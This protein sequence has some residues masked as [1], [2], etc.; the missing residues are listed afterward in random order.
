MAQAAQSTAGHQTA[1][2]WATT[3]ASAM[4]ASSACRTTRMRTP[5][6]QSVQWLRNVVRLDILHSVL[7]LANVYECF[8]W[9]SQTKTVDLKAKFLFLVTF[10]NLSLIIIIIIII[11]YIIII[12]IEY[13]STGAIEEEKERNDKK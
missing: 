10:L 5:T 11:I 9:H 4:A 2:S 13:T 1:M 12:I 3:A 6:A 7:C 8:C